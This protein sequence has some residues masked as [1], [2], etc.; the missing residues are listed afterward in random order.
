MPEGELDTNALERWLTE[1]LPGAHAVRLGEVDRCTLGYS[2]ETFV[3]PV[4]V[5]RAAGEHGAAAS[6]ERF[7]LRREVAGPAVYPTQVPG[8]DVEI[9]IQYRAMDAVARTSSVPIA[10]LIGYESD[11]SIL[12]DPF[13]VMGFVEGVVPVVE[14]PYTRTGFFAD[15][16]PADRR[17]MIEDGLRVLG[18]LHQ[19]DWRAA[20]LEWLVPDGVTPGTATQLEVWSSYLQRELGDR[21][22]P[23]L[24]AA[25]TWLHANVPTDASVGL[26]W[27][28]ASAT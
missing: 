20:G 15:A 24:E 2:A 13:F 17:G 3:V 7:V 23:L 16:A 19:I 22:H 10:P 6:E 27:G 11:A 28:R 4:T 21:S 9:D 12:G 1:R 25:L 5:E 18:E 26:C 14:P 8:L